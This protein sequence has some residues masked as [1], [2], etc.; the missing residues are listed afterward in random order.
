VGVGDGVVEGAGTS[1]SGCGLG[2]SGGEGDG[3]GVSGGAGVGCPGCEGCGVCGGG[4]SGGGCW[5]M[6]DPFEPSNA[7]TA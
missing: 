1:M 7:A 3:T 6:S 4:V 2:V 5:A